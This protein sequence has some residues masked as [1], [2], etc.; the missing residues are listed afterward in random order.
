MGD[1]KLKAKDALELSVALVAPVPE[2]GKYES[3][4]R[5]FECC[6]RG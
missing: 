1:F 5:N 2:L 4:F 3:G 6:W